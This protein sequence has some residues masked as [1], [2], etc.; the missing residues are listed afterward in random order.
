MKKVNKHK[1]F[2]S[3]YHLQNSVLISLYAF[4]VEFQ[5][6]IVSHHII[7]YYIIIL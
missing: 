5:L 2:M 4:P 1:F 7:K 6:D 3:D